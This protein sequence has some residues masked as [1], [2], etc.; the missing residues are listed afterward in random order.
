MEEVGRVFEYGDEADVVRVEIE[1][2]EAC[3]HCSSRSICSPLG[4]NRRMVTEAIN[5]KGARPGDIVRLKMEPKST[6]GAALLLYVLPVLT[7]L[8]GYM[9]GV[10]FLGE[11]IHGIVAG[12]GALVFSFALL[13]LL[14]PFLAKGRRFQPVVFEIVKKGD[15]E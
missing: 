15:V 1:A 5:T 2:K 10:S 4:D 11:E 7:L 9:L 13:R 12:I 3:Q 8:L 6:V 14:N